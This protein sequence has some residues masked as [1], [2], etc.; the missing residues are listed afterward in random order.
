LFDT[1]FQILEHP[2]SMGCDYHAP[3]SLTVSAIGPGP[4]TYQWK[5]DKANINDEDCTGVD[6]ATLTIKS[7]SQK[8]EGCYSCEVAY[9]GNTVESDP[10]K[11]E[12]SK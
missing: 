3:V 6:E 12:L 7:F 2:K 4:L 11:L 8:Y 1:D 10:A 9:I 5:R